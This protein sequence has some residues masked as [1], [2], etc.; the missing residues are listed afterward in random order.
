VPSEPYEFK[1][2]HLVELREALPM[3]TIIEID[4]QDLFWWGSRT[5]A[6]VSR[7]QEALA[8]PPTP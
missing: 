1:P 7:L 4:G 8:R 6:A 5:P 3:A 2:E